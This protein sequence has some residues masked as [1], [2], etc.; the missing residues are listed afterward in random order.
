MA[1]HFHSLAL[2]PSLL[3][4]LSPIAQA[5]AAQNSPAA[6][7]S[8]AYAQKLQIPGVPNAGKINDRFYRGAQPTARAF[9]E[10]KKIGVTTIVDLRTEDSK[11]IIWERQQAESQ[12]MHFVNIPVGG[13]SAP[14]DQQVAEF[15]SL[16]L[17]NPDEKIFV[18]CHYGEDRTGVFV[19][20]Y[21]MAIDRWP[22]EQAVHEM[23]LFG[24]NARWQ[25]RMKDFARDF[26]YRLT[27]APAYSSLKID[28]TPTSNSRPH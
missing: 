18:H 5:P 3:F 12:G 25:P 1:R 20:S 14:A 22:A 2:L 21:R 27:A 16:F 15:L 10:L 7:L 13:F 28:R 19:A 26:P 4:S 6:T 11:T 23:H 9:S 17:S 24:F 8:S